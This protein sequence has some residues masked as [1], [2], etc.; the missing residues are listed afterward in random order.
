MSKF[1][2]SHYQL[3]TCS[4]RHATPQEAA[5]LGKEFEKI[6]PWKTLGTTKND[7]EH[8]ILNQDHYDTY[9]VIA[10]DKPIG[11][12][13]IR[14]PWLLGPYLAF[15]GILPQAQGKGFGT[16]LMQW[17]EDT[18]RIHKARN[19]FI[20]V[21]DFNH[22]AQ[23]FYASCGYRKVADLEGLVLDEYGELLLRKRLT[24]DDDKH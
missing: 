3:A 15:L 16:T 14:F 24:Q 23:A 10:D 11:M 6:D 1:G 22:D 4:L 5:F 20:C 8:Y 21:S 19:I 18:A 17:L 2:E 13:S 9:A 12:I 7:L